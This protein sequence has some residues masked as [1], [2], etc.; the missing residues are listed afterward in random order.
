MVSRQSSRYGRVASM[1]V[2]DTRTLLCAERFQAKNREL[3]LE[4][5]L[6]NGNAW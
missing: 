1:W 3:E 2:D 6:N 5:Q 4:R